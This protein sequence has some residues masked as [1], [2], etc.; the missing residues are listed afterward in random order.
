MRTL[1]RCAG[2]AGA[3]GA[4]TIVPA[5]ADTPAP[6]ATETVLTGKMA[7]MQFLVGSWNCDVKVAASASGPAGTD[8]GVVT[9]SVVPGNAL[10]LHV[11]AADYAADSY[12]SYV[13]KTNTYWMSTIDAY[14]NASIET[15]ADGKV[16]AGSSTGSGATTQIRDTFTRPS[17]GTIRDLQEFQTNGAWSTATDST[18]TRI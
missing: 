1:F 18:C 8:H 14:G 15:S 10:H 2:L 4:L 6:A 13:E 7:S 11:T 17:T 12:S 9:Y 5:V 16:F 3:I